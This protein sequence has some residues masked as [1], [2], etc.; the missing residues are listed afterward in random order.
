VNYS[1]AYTSRVELFILISLSSLPYSILVG[2]A[3]FFASIVG[4]SHSLFYFYAYYISA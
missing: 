2:L 3:S 4:F 1:T